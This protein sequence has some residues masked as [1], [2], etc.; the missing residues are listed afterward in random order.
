MLSSGARKARLAF[1]QG[2]GPE[3]ASEHH[4]VAVHFVAM[5]QGKDFA[6]GD[7]DGIA[8][9]SNGKGIAY[10]LPKVA[11]FRGHRRLQPTFKREMGLKQGCCGQHG[12]LAQPPSLSGPA[13]PLGMLPTTEMPNLSFRLTP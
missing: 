1:T 13:H 4:L 7:A 12:A 10:H 9:H 11:D 2:G 5:F 3:G 6:Q 8:Y